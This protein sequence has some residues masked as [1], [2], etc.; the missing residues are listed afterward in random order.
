MT[1]LQSLI[2]SLLLV[3]FTS[4]G[5]TACGGAGGES[6]SAADAKVDTDTQLVMAEFK[7]HAAIE[8]RELASR[9]AGTNANEGMKANADSLILQMR[10]NP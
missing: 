8:N 10:K 4:V 2:C 7:R 6:K 9:R 3:I 5:L 1:K